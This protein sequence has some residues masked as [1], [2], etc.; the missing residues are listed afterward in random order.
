MT[1][2][3]K[4]TFIVDISK[5]AGS[6]HFSRCKAVYENLLRAG[7]NPEK[8]AWL[9]VGQD[10][11]EISHQFLQ[12]KTSY[13]EKIN[14]DKFE[15]KISK[16][17]SE[18][19]FID[20][21][22]QDYRNYQEHVPKR[23]KIVLI[24]DRPIGRYDVDLLISPNLFLNENI[25]S[26][27]NINKSIDCYLGPEWMP[28]RPEFY[29]YGILKTKL[30]R[31]NP[32][33]KVGAYFGRLDS[34]NQINKV[35]QVAME[36]NSNFFEFDV[37]AGTETQITAEFQDA[38]IIKVSNQ[39]S[40]FPAY[41]KGCDIFI[42][43]LGVSAWERCF[44]KTPSITSYQNDNQIEDY[45]VM[46]GIDAI[47]GI[48]HAEGYSNSDLLQALRLV[49]ND[50]LLRQKLQENSFNIMRENKEKSAILIARILD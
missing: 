31:N 1:K 43:S 41:L 37:V 30:L 21:P 22:E 42:G 3:I 23:S 34:E 33:L 49:S 7:L 14:S 36:L 29:D 17:K 15:L 27:R 48:G 2:S 10:Y 39:K 25:K 50:F 35:C 9:L 32:P 6:G 12:L 40:N 5:R 38:N 8:T 11:D 28:L 45:K 46:S 16:I 20:L 44:M 18:Y 19:I 24:I 47:V 13:I 4:I 26:I